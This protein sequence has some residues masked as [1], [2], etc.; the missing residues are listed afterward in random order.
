MLPTFNEADNLRALVTE[1]RRYLPETK[2]MI[3]DDHSFDGTG[4]I[5]D[6]LCSE[7]PLHI[8]VLHRP[9]REGLGL[10]YREAF[11]K[12]LTEDSA[13]AIIQMDADF[14]HPPSLLPLL[15]TQLAEYDFVLA[16]RYVPG[17]GISEWNWLRR[18]LSLLG[19]RYAQWCLGKQIQ[20]WTGGFKAYRQNVLKT[21]LHY[22]SYGQGYLFQIETSYLAWKH[23]FSY[24][25]I[26]FTFSER[27]Q[28]TSKMNLY[29]CWEAFYKTPQLRKRYRFLNHAIKYPQWDPNKS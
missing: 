29:I 14:S 23:G 6:S 16:S 10:A 3:V 8:Q 21:L 27:R 20:D 26:P 7:D 4:E 28:G 12:I 24:C 2:L 18:R 1:I 22:S 15:I 25:E 13:E 19:N 17:G 9:R 5:A 11:Q